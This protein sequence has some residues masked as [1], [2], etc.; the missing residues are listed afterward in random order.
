MY[1]KRL[2]V[3]SANAKSAKYPK[4]FEKLNQYL[5]IRNVASF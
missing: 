1:A 5:I 2:H 4:L 3:K